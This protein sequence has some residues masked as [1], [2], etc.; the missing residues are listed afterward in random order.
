VLAHAEGG[1]D[2]RAFHGRAQEGSDGAGAVAVEPA[3]LAARWLKPVERPRLGRRFHGDVE[4]SADADRLPAPVHAV[5][6]GRLED[7]AGVNLALKVE[8]VGK[9]LSK[10]RDQRVVEM[11]RHGRGVEA[12]GVHLAADDLDRRLEVGGR[13]RG[14]QRAIFGHRDDHAGA[15]VMAGLEVDQLET[16][17]DGLQHHDNREIAGRG[18]DF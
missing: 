4:Q 1:G 13:G 15:I 8:V 3:A 18:G 17:L 11:L 7:I 5:L 14:G 9:R 6:E 10:W 16:V 2:P 12:I